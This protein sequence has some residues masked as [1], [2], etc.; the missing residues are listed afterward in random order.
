MKFKPFLNKYTT[1]PI[2]EKKVA[3]VVKAYGWDI[4]EELQH[5]ISACKREIFVEND[6]FSADFKVLSLD[7]I[8]DAETDLGIDFRAL[9]MI[10]V[11]DCYD[12][13]FLVY[14]MDKRNWGLYS[15][16][17]DIIFDENE[18][19]EE[20][21][22]L[23]RYFERVLA[24][25]ESGDV[26]AM[27]ELG[28]C[29][30]S[31]I[32]VRSNG[33]KSLTWYKK[34]AEIGNSEAMKN[35]AEAYR[36][37][38]G[39]KRD[40]AKA[41]VWYRMAANSGNKEAQATLEKWLSE[42]EKERTE[43]EQRQKKAAEGDVVS[44]NYLGRSYLGG[45]HLGE[46]DVEK[47]L[48]CLLKA[49]ELGYAPAMERLGEYYES[50][51]QDE[52]ALAWYRKAAEQEIPTSVAEEED[53]HRRLRNPIYSSIVDSIGRIGLFYWDGRGVEKDRD[54]A[55][56]WFVQASN[57]GD[58]IILHEHAALLFWGNENVEKDVDK[59]I[60]LFTISGNN[61]DISSMEW[62]AYWF[63]KGEQVP[64][65]LEKAAY[66]EKKIEEWRNPKA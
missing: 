53:P 52:M 31:G 66:W 36:H 58:R 4:P 40:E 37:G 61:G 23:T 45:Y 25:A 33:S 43:W 65:D 63:K 19:M 6:S 5:F 35:I 32:G 2:D 42:K 54:K 16:D 46:K 64:K 13:Q 50:T 27:V 41:E 55:I 24:K 38:Y 44:L 39:V 3:K 26:E 10:P 48:E 9:K 18:S 21:L 49:A 8:I 28:D 47:G 51:S 1:A 59:A 20:L 14:Q 12:N 22:S 62:L 30:S 15:M 11:I 34:A 7:E 17:D 57:M 60:E 56:E 29:Y